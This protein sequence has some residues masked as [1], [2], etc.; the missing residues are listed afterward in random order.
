[1]DYFNGGRMKYSIKQMRKEV[2]SMEEFN[3]ENYRGSIN[4]FDYEELGAILGY[5]D[6]G[7]G[8]VEE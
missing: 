3:K 7:A 8:D 2:S 5:W 4:D 1:M 6:V